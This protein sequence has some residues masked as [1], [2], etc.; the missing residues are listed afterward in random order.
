M[1]GMREE[2]SEELML[3]QLMESEETLPQY[4]SEGMQAEICLLTG[5]DLHTF[6]KW[7][8]FEQFLQVASRAGHDRL[9]WGLLPQK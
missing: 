8:C 5:F 2:H 9:S 3:K 1:M 7:P 6:A 4:I